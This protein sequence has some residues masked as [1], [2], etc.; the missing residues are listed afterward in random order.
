MRCKGIDFRGDFG[1][2]VHIPRVFYRVFDKM[3]YATD[4]V[5]GNIFIKSVQEFQN[6][7]TAGVR[8]DENEGKFQ[9]IVD[10]C[11]SDNVFYSKLG[12][13]I[14]IETNEMIRNFNL[15][16]YDRLLLN[17]TYCY[18]ILC[19]SYVDL[20]DDKNAIYKVLKH[21]SKFGKYFVFFDFAE[22]SY[23][24]NNVISVIGSSIEYSDDTLLHPFVKKKKFSQENEYRFLFLPSNEHYVNIPP[25]VRYKICTAN[26]IFESIKNST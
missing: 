20:N 24:L 26:N 18:R 7:A 22:L 6:V 5:N 4:F 10:I 17:S 21:C 3:E 2:S 9:D 1:E 25:L 8:G 15:R 23:K 16:L 12:N 19:C 14:L 13:R 11:T